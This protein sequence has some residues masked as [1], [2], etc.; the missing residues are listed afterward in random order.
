MTRT[1]R[2]GI[3]AA[4][5][6][7]AFGII[8]AQVAA[9]PAAAA[10]APAAEPDVVST[11]RWCGEEQAGNRTLANELKRRERELDDREHSFSARQQ[12]LA[13]AE[14]RLDARI[15]ALT[16]LRN[17]LQGNVAQADDAREVRVKALVKMVESNRAA[18]IAPMVSQLDES[19]AV[20]VLDRM[21]RVKAGKLL[22]ALAPAKAASL[23]GK[24][25]RPLQ[26]DIP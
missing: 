20:E 17:D 16:K 10:P 9:M 22:A 19:L 5:L 7:L 24:L 1:L 6:V 21:N 11:L 14:K 15:A 8:A 26:A 23:A 13:D 2:A 25:T 4:G 18:S 12:G 3:V